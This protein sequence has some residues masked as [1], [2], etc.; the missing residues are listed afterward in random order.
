MGKRR[1][2]TYVDLFTQ[3]ALRD[4]LG[5][6]CDA[7]YLTG[8]VGRELVDDAG[9]LSP[10][11]FNARDESLSTKPAFGSNF[12]RDAR[13]LPRELAQAINHDVDHLLQANHDAALHRNHN[14]LRQIARSHRFTDASDIVDLVVHKT[15]Q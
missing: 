2:Y 3:I 12:V 15:Y 5:D 6:L 13:D 10:C 7:P 4:S 9:E 11:A 8:E 14:L 1:I